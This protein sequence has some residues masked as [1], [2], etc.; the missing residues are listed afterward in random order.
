M[1]VRWCQALQGWGVTVALPV[2]W[3]ALAGALLARLGAL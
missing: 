3:V 1:D 2:L